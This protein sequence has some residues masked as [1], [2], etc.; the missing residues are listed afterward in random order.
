MK[1]FTTL[2]AILLTATVLGCGGGGGGGSGGVP[3][4]P[5]NPATTNSYV[6]ST[7]VLA[8]SS[9]NAPKGISIDPQGNLYV[10]DS[11]ANLIRKIAN[12]NTSPIVSTVL[13]GGNTSYSSC[14]NS[15]LDS[16]YAIAIDSSSHM[17][18]AELNKPAIRYADCT[19]LTT[20]SQEYGSVNVAGLTLSNAS[21]VVLYNNNNITTL[22]VSDAGN[23]KIRAITDNGSHSGTTSTLAGTTS[24]YVNAVAGSAAFARP[25]GIAVDSAGRIFVADT[26]NCAIR[27]IAAGQVSTFAGASPNNLGTGP[28]AC[29]S[30]DGS[31]TAARFDHPTGIAIDGSNNV[32]V[33]DSANNKIRL[34]TPQGV[35]TTIAGTGVIGSADGSGSSATFNTPTGITIDTSGNLFVVDSGSNTI[36]KITVA[37]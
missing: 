2:A 6:V 13:G 1:T 35:V 30:T 21:G 9:L 3:S 11:G 25:T 4:N 22:Y 37:H 17:Y 26:D 5:S 23:H 31:D 36:R 10:A 18:V 7:L 24:G 33:A 16:P 12:V 20:F 29:G 28:L 15:V 34:I 27:V 14:L 32:Y 19:A 8:G